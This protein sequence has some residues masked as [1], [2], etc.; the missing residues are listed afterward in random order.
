MDAITLLRRQF[1]LMHHVL[2]Q[3][4]ADLTAE[5]VHAAPGGRAMTIAANWVHLVNGED[6]MA[7]LA[8]N[9]PDLSGSEWAGRTGASELEQIDADWDMAAW[10]QRVTIDPAQ[11]RTYMQAVHTRTLTLLATLHPA[12]LDRS[13]DPSIWGLPEQP[14][15]TF[16]GH[17][18]EDANWH[19]GEI[20]A[21]KGLQGLRG[22]PF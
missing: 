8:F 1:T 6:A 2:T 11:W 19:T 16:L 7:A 17:M 3:V 10:A 22:Y 9:V 14:L 21:L 5:Q 18:L 12:D 20:S 4:T 13:V 15:G